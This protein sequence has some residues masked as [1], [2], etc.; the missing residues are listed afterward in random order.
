LHLMTHDWPINHRRSWSFA[1]VAVVATAI[2]LTLVPATANALTATVEAD[3]YSAWLNPAGTSNGDTLFF[4][5]F[6]GLPGVPLLDCDAV[7]CIPSDE[8]A[9]TFLGSRTFVTDYLVSDALGVYEYGTATLN[10]SAVDNDGDGQLDAFERLRPGNFS[11]SGTT[12]PDWNAFN[13]Y[14]NSTVS[15]SVSRTAGSRI[16]TYSGTFVNPFQS[17][18]FASGFGLSGANGSVSYD[19]AGTTLFWTLQQRSFDGQVRNFTGVSSIIRLGVNAVQIPSFSL[20]DSAS[21]LSILTKNAILNRFGNHFRGVVEAFDG[22]LGTT[23]PDYRY[24]LVDVTDNNDTDAN[25][26]PDLLAVCGNGVIDG[27]ESCDDGGA[28]GTTLCGCT[29]NCRYPVAG[30]AC[31]NTTVCDGAETCNGTG[32][33]VAGTPLACD[34]GNVCTGT[35]TCDPVLGCQPGTPLACDDSNICTDDSC[36]PVSGCTYTN[37]AALCDDGNICTVLDTCTNGSCVGGAPLDCDDQ[38][39]CTADGCDGIGGCFNEPI[40]GC[41]IP[42][43]ASTPRG[44][45]VLALLLAAVSGVT[46]KKRARSRE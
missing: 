44:L 2:A 12:V 17:A 10:V 32:G 13:L 14:V 26:L 39:P 45:A 36:N 3:G 40:P 16:G 24:F 23:W 4:T 20:F 18:S 19:L 25:G 35:E 27:G 7:Q 9:P 29:L 28:N 1:S 8:I 43:P 15:A 6:D 5:T 31:D 22:E 34:D 21:G 37:N 38:N 33:C 30:T 46:L 42:V 41:G 11:L